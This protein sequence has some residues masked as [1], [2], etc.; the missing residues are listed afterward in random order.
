ME[1]KKKS[2]FSK[3]IAC[4]FSTLPSLYR[5]INHLLTLMKYETHLARRS[6]ITL[7]LL[8]LL[9]GSLLASVWICLLAMLF[10][11]FISLHLTWLTSLIILLILNIL[12]LVI[13]LLSMLLVKNNLSFPKTRELLHHL[14]QKELW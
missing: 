13:V 10:M 2:S 14:R 5:L 11:Y 3:T 8:Y 1:E 7:L 12:L 4:V 6:V 9:A